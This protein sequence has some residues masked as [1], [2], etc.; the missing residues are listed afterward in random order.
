MSGI[1]LSHR[2]ATRGDVPALTALMNA[3]IAALLRRI[4]WRARVIAGVWRR[5]SAASAAQPREGAAVL[6][7][8]FLPAAAGASAP[9]GRRARCTRLVAYGLPGVGAP[10]LPSF[11]IVLT[12]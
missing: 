2:L 1:I 12:S 8:F 4:G 9:Y 3:A 10:P 5:V 6:L 11:A 7:G